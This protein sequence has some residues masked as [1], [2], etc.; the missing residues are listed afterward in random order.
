VVS[1]SRDDGGSGFILPS[2]ALSVYCTIGCSLGNK[3]GGNDGISS[4]SAAASLSLSLSLSLRSLCC[5]GFVG[6]EEE[7]TQLNNETTTVQQQRW[8]RPL[9]VDRDPL[10][11]SP[12]IPKW[13]TL[14]RFWICAFLSSDTP[15]PFLYAFFSCVQEK[16]CCVLVLVVVF[17]CGTFSRCMKMMVTNVQE[18]G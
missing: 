14:R 4:R 16:K 13:R 2:S 8:S 18:I 11:F 5:T 17:V 1:D 15:I 6:E 3:G 9:P 10:P 12:T 7:E